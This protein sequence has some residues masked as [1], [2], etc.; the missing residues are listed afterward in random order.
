MTIPQSTDN[1]LTLA[2]AIYLEVNESPQTSTSN[3]L[4]TKAKSAINSA[5]SDLCT[6][7]DWSWLS[8][9]QQAVSWAN[10]IA[11][12]PA[13]TRQIKFVIQERSGASARSIPYMNPQTFYQQNLTSFTGAGGA[14]I[15]NYTQLGYLDVGVNP[16]PADAASQQEVKFYVARFVS[17]PASDT[18]VFDIPDEFMPLLRIKA[19]ANFALSH[20]ADLNLATQ[21]STEYEILVQRYR[22][23]IRNTPHSGLN[24]YRNFRN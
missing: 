1:L 22:D 17:L 4:G 20:L 9:F 21:F 11:T 19:T 12:L 23:M 18:S 8:S 14:N 24:L 15:R 3:S 7:A 16:Y 10:E 2:N 13:N 5:L 6:R